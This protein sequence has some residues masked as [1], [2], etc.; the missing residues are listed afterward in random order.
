M[1]FHACVE[2]KDTSV[3]AVFVHGDKLL[4]TFNFKDGTRTIT[5]IDAQIAV[6]ENTGSN[7]DCLGHHAAADSIPFAAA[8]SFLSGRRRRG[9]GKNGNFPAKKWFFRE[10][11][12]GFFRL[13]KKK[14]KNIAEFSRWW[15]R[16]CGNILYNKEDGTG[17]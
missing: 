12:T 3:N 11:G 2:A 13:K 16:Y 9:N 17:L 6:K 15:H 8:F 7:L 4:L 14:Q 1:N 5:L 10:P